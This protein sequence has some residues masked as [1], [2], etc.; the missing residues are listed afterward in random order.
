MLKTYK[1]NPK[2]LIF[3]TKRKNPAFVLNL[4]H[5]LNIVLLWFHILYIL[6]I[7]IAELLFSLQTV[8]LSLK[9]ISLCHKLKF[10]NHY[11]FATQSFTFDIPNYDFCYIKKN[12]N[13][14]METSDKNPPPL[15][16][17]FLTHEKECK[18]YSLCSNPLKFNFQL[19]CLQYF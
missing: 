6:N 12:R 9:Q 18:N 1:K 2:N 7:V 3:I 10:S 15:S 14:F 8:I 11:I 19:I 5:H 4:L 17:S 16:S 13:W